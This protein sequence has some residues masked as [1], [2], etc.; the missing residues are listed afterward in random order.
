MEQKPFVN[1]PNFG[2]LNATKA[3]KNPQEP[4]YWGEVKVDLSTVD[5]ENNVATVKLGGW[6]K[7]T[8]NGNTWLSLKVNTWKGDGKQQ[9]KSADTGIEDDDIPF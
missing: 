1:A 2:N 4:D 3:K 5:I 9:A 8:A 6:R 7:K